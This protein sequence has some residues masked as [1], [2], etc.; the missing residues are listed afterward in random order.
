M[1][2]VLNWWLKRSEAVHLWQPLR[3]SGLATTVRLK[4]EKG[5]SFG[6]ICLDSDLNLPL[7]FE[8]HI[9]Y[10]FRITT[11]KSPAW[12]SR[13]NLITTTKEFGTKKYWARVADIASASTNTNN[14]EHRRSGSFTFQTCSDPWCL[15]D[16]TAEIGKCYITFLVFMSRVMSVEFA[17]ILNRGKEMLA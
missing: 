17:A 6:L 1:N 4:W 13:W 15:E 3:K 14:E 2:P 7:A 8:Q 16:Y 9:Q 10:S 5:G 12:R 11:K